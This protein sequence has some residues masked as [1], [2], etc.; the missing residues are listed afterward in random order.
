MVSSIF[1]TYSQGENRVT[2]SIIQVLQNLPVNVVERFLEMFTQDDEGSVAHSSQEP[3][4]RFK[5][6]PKGERS[7]P[8]AEISAKFSVLIETKIKPNS[9][10]KQQLE[11]HLRLAQRGSSLVYLTPDYSCPNILKDKD[12]TWKNFQNVY[13]LIDELIREPTL[14]MSERDQFL[15]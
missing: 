5:N 6:Q 3:F 14:I 9:V 11:E 7:V 13:D 4:F 1:S 2:S 15:L 8:D 10:R 12:V